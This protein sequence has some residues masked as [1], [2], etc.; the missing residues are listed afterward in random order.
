MSYTTISID[1]K[2]HTQT[3]IAAV[4]Q[5]LTVKAFT[6][7]ALLDAINRAESE[8]PRRLVDPAVEYETEE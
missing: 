8:N 5:G 2:V 3:K 6:E 7:R 1:P 4:L